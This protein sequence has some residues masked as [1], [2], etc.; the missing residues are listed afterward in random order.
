MGLPENEFER[1]RFAI[2]ATVVREAYGHARNFS[3]KGR[4]PRHEVG[5]ER[6]ANA[7]GEV[8]APRTKRRT[9]RA[10]RQGGPL[11]NFVVRLAPVLV[12][13][14]RKGTFRTTTGEPMHESR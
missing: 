2:R 1:I 9:H 14:S 11:A 3:D 10:A 13:I 5:A 12:P 4:P 8:T 6:Q 7:R